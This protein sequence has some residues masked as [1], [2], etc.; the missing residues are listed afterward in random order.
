MLPL[1]GAQINSCI[2]VKYTIDLAFSGFKLSGHLWCFDWRQH[3]SCFFSVSHF[4]FIIWC[5]YWGLEKSGQLKNGKLIKRCCPVWA[6]K[7]LHKYPG[8]WRGL[9][10]KAWASLR[11]SG[12]SPPPNKSVTHSL[13]LSEVRL[14]APGEL[15]V[16]CVFVMPVS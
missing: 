1:N 10:L 2:F 5:D 7:H 9:K 3:L 13:N 14:M 6:K 11:L 12:V 16:N 4:V 15:P 8:H